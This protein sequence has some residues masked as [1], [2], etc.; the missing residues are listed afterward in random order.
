MPLRSFNKIGEVGRRDTGHGHYEELQKSHALNLQLIART[1]FAA[2]CT[3]RN[4]ARTLGT[5][6][7]ADY[8]DWLKGYYQYCN[9][10]TLLNFLIE[11]NVGAR[12]IFAYFM[13]TAHLN[14][15]TIRS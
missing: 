13:R 11:R 7:V 12:L 4:I 6:L 1:Q 15:F 5:V 10:L 8:R 2:N 9:R 14:D 3:R